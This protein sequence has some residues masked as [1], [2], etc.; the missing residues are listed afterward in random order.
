MPE[1]LNPR[2]AKLSKT[3]R[4]RPFRFPMRESEDA[5]KQGLL[6]QPSDACPHIRLR[7]KPIPASVMSMATSVDAGISNLAP[8][9]GQGDMANVSETGR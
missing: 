3:M 5:D 9:A 1:A 7:P 8:Q 2:L 4:A 6:D